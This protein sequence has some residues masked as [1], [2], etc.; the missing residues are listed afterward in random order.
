MS[1]ETGT[2]S[3]R[4]QILSLLNKGGQAEVNLMHP[5]ER[6]FRDVWNALS[7]ALLILSLQLGVHAQATDF[8][9]LSKDATGPIT[10]VSLSLSLQ[11]NT[12]SDQTQDLIPN[13]S[14]LVAN[15]FTMV[16]DGQGLGSFSGSASIVTLDGRLILEGFLHGTVGLNA[17]RGQGVDCHAPGH[18]EGLL[19][20]FRLFSAPSATGNSGEETF[21]EKSSST[22]GLIVPTRQQVTISTLIFSADEVPEIA[23]PL[24]IYRARLDGLIRPAFLMPR[25]RIAPDRLEYGESDQ[26]TAII[27][28]SS[29]TPIQIFDGRSY[30]TIVQLQRQESNQWAQV[31]GCPLARPSQPVII[32]VGETRQV[33][34]PPMTD[35]PASKEAGVY[36]LALTLTSLNKEGKPVGDTITIT[37][38]PFRVIASPAVVTV[39]TDRTIYTVEDQIV[40]KVTTNADRSI[41]TTDHHSYCSILTLQRQEDEQWNNVAPCLLLTPTRL[42]TIGPQQ[43]ISVTLP[44]EL[45]GPLPQPGTYRVGFS[46]VFLDIKG[47]PIGQPVE[48]FSEPF[49]VVSLM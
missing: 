30:C 26:I 36:R 17:S 25:V 23:G 37:S 19:E 12:A 47:Q 38:A 40:V 11:S 46:F 28:N 5:K 15:G 13:G 7:F 34:L 31:A 42:I 22:A 3:D 20:G 8:L 29:D 6:M 32:G 24:P 43:S 14:R 35:V 41:Q 27:T 45:A 48:V 39:T 49:S 21:V 4:C 33:M 16:A 18:L 1:L 2:H 9:I 10:G 44:P